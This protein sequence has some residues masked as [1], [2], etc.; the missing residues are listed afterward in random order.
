M[1]PMGIATVPL[2]AR[3]SELAATWPG[4][5]A[6]SI[7]RSPP[8]M[9][10]TLTSTDDDDAELFRAAI[11]PCAGCARHAAPP[12][13]KPTPAT[14]RARAWPS[15]TRPM[16]ASEFRRALD[17]TAAL[18]RRRRAASTVATRCRRALLQR[19][20]RGQYR[21][22]GRTRPARTPTR[23][24]PKRCCGVSC[25]EAA[26]C[27]ASAACA[28]STARAC[29][30]RRRSGMPVLKNLVDRMLRQRADVLAFHSAPA[31]QGGTGAVLVLL[32]PSR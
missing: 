21:G 32:A 31:A 29:S 5:A 1:T 10:A 23:R 12:P 4:I 7:P 16:R 3:S 11:G 30:S 19:L 9:R 13:A 6:S 15:A 26:R 17:D 20:Q 18:E 24:R 22:A 25:D 14:P 28:S 2:P 8:S 27:T